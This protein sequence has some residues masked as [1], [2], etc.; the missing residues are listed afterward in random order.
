[1][2][3]CIRFPRYHPVKDLSKENH[4][5]SAFVKNG[6]MG[7]G[8]QFGFLKGQKRIEWKKRVKMHKKIEKN[9]AKI[10]YFFFFLHQ[11]FSSIGGNAKKSSKTRVFEQLQRGYK[12][13]SGFSVL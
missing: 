1:M 3:G 4:G 12:F 7:F 10:F 2:E 11:L 13:D 9:S 8:L 5:I 6:K